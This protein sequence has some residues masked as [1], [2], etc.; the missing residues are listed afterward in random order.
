[1]RLISRVIGALFLLLLIIVAG[2]AVW[3]SILATGI[4]EGRR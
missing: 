2:G 1:M 4:A 3:L